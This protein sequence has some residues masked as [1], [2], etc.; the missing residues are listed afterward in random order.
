MNKLKQL[1]FDEDAQGLVE[2]I[3][4]IAVIAVAAVV[5]VKAFGG[6]IQAWFDKSGKQLDDGL[7][8]GDGN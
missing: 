1:I 2:Y 5:V 8:L 4:I 3:L 7:G 6:K